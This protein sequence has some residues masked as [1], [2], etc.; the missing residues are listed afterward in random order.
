MYKYAKDREEPPL[1]AVTAS[2][3]FL[4]I[5]NPRDKIGV[6]AR[7]TPISCS[8][9]LEMACLKAASLRSADGGPLFYWF[10]TFT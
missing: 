4:S 5:Q 3:G 6:N 7:G 10:F 1:S 9:E 8:I 2:I